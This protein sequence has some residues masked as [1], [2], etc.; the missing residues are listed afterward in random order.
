MTPSPKKGSR[1]LFF[2]MGEVSEMF[3]VNP[4]LIRF[5]EKR[6]P[7]LKPRKNN[8][9]NRLFTPEDI[10]NLKLIYHLV[11]EKRMTL[12]GAEK[13]IRDNKASIRDNKNSLKREVQVVEHLQRI[14][15]TLLEI[16]AELGDQTNETQIVL[17]GIDQPDFPDPSEAADLRESEPPLAETADPQPDVPVEGYEVSVSEDFSFPAA[18]SPAETPAPAPVSEKPRYIEPTLF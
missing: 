14:R 11:R 7:I 4:S 6:F 18:E 3:D 13:Y 9:G 5:W 10:E 12:E 2:S 16:K 8:K 17:T 15:A 1:K